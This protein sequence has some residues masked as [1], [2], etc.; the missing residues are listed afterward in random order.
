[1]AVKYATRLVDEVEFYAEDA[2]R[3]DPTFLAQMV[4]KVILAGA[5][6]V[7]IP[8]TTGYCLPEEFGQ[9]IKY[10]FENVKNIEKAII[11]VH[12]HNDL[13]L[14]TANAL[15]GIFNGA[16]QV[17]VTINGVGERAGNTSLEEVVMILRSHK[18]LGFETNINTR[19]IYSVSRLV[20]RLMKMPIQ[21]N[22]AIVG[23]NAFSHSS[24][25]HQDGVLK[26]RQNYE[27]INPEEVGVPSS[28]IILT[29]RSGRAALKFR[30]EKLGHKIKSNKELNKIYQRFLKLADQKK[31]IIDD[32]LEILIGEK[33]EKR[34]AELLF[35]QVT[36]GKP[37]QA[38]ALVKLKNKGKEE[39]ATAFGSGPIDATF[40]AVDKIIKKKVYLEE[41]LVQSL[42]GGSDDIGKVHVQIRHKNQ[43]YYGFGADTDIVVA[44]AKAYLDSLN[45]IKGY[46]VK[47]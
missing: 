19:K 24:G 44:S 18:N 33:E 15:A 26:Y 6:I 1:M 2:G 35:L 40:K 39:T 16:R 8:D 11:S 14:A 5:K 43:I 17:E 3:A 42:T 21:F 31:E 45:K 10:L 13:G 12:C 36:C 30:L 47:E 23:K 28:Q 32:D 20:S 7:N 22:K 29:A 38:L 27:I 37:F 41:Y 46:G 9:K 4:E 34:E 25:I